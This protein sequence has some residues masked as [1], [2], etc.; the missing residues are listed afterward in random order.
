MKRKLQEILQEKFDYEETCL[1]L[2]DMNLRFSAVE[3]EVFEGT[4]L[5][6]SS[7]AQEVRGMI[8]CENP[9]VT[10]ETTEFH[11]TKIQVR[12]QY[13]A[14][15]MAE[16]MSDQGTFVI[17]SNV[18]EYLLPFRADITRHYLTS[19]IGK[20]KTLNDFTN[21]CKLNWEEALRVFKSPYFVNVLQH[22]NGYLKLLYR[23]LTQHGRGT[24]EMEEFLVGCGK[25]KRNGFCI[26]RPE[27]TY[28]A[29]TKIQT[30]FLDIEKQE[31]GDIHIEAFSDA[32]FIRL[33]KHQIGM[34]DF[35]GKHAEL[36]YQIVPGG[37]HAG[38]N[39]GRILL[40]T[41]F[42]TEAVQIEVTMPPQHPEKS[43]AWKSTKLRARMEQKYLEFCREELTAAQWKEEMEPLLT[44]AERIHPDNEW[45]LLYQIYAL[46][47]CGEKAEADRL[48]HNMARTIT[49]QRT[50]LSAFYLYL[51]TI[52]E[53]PSY[54]R[55]VTKRIREIY[56]KYPNHPVLV[57]ILLRT[58]EAL[59][60]NPERKYQWLRKYM[61]SGSCS[62]VFYEETAKLLCNHPELLRQFDLFERR[63]L[64]WM[65]KQGRLTSGLVQRIFAMAQSQKQFEPL[66]FQLLCRG[67][68]MNPEE[69]ALR[70]ICGYL[71]K[72]NQYGDV[73]FPWF[74]KG[75][76]QHLKIAG[77][78]EAY[79]LSWNKANGMLPN[80]VLHYFSRNSS[81]PAKRKAMLYAHMVKN[82]KRL[83]KSWDA[84]LVL[85]RNFAK[86]ELLAGEMNEDLA[87]IYE[88]VRRQCTKAEWDSWK[89]QAE[90]CYRI[91]VMNDAMPNLHI[92]QAE[93]EE[94]QQVPVF[95][96]GTYIYLEKKPFVVLYESTGGRLYTA[97]DQFHLKKML[98]GTHIYQEEEGAA[99][100]Q[101]SDP[102]ADSRSLKEQLDQF[103]GPLAVMEERIRAAEA[104][105]M[106][107]QPYEEKLMLHMLFTGTFLPEHE[108][109][110]Q[111]LTECETEEVLLRAYETWFSWQ[112][113]RGKEPFP[114]AVR[115]H[116]R[117][118]LDKEPVRQK[119]CRAA[120]LKNCACDS[121]KPEQED[122]Q[123]A[124]RI[125]KGFVLEQK[126]FDFYAKLPEKL[127]RKYLL[128]GSDAVTCVDT[129]GEYLRICRTAPGWQDKTGD[130]KEVLP[131]I[132]SY[133][134]REIRSCPEHYVIRNREGDCIAEGTLPASETENWGDTRYGKLLRLSAAGNTQDAYQY[135]E[136]TDLTDVLFQA[137]EE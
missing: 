81:L 119:F 28:K 116:L 67:Y 29:G 71:I 123:I 10:C 52:G 125:L 77:L 64:V 26:A 137:I 21:L 92:L 7:S 129:P 15:A 34:Y 134:C 63:V 127:Q 110:Y 95:D 45:T 4:F 6:H 42:Q 73:Y 100:E 47:M 36:A 99:Q 102:A 3:N 136:L 68:R 130:M 43:D 101:K 31:W 61:L 19:S 124:E 108:A 74:Q 133:T 14:D 49:S 84:Y 69:R 8:T 128:F 126:A 96:R 24:H 115:A 94:I 104:Q 132:Y 93:K 118:V 79:I 5:F 27:R 40:K 50:P 114:Q 1:L 23:G 112:Y 2:P 25:K 30:D 82:R 105:G 91:R 51:T 109:V 54:I 131:G 57:W 62:P 66:F 60:R 55:D 13:R 17:T 87:V 113:M 98:S 59:V 44:E 32:A 83:G 107:V 22:D 88:E 78:Y 135:A 86:Q 65:M 111:K 80:E 103:A 120:F 121:E 56:L 35:I 117:Q 11:G 41:A 20:I 97:R 9:H 37:L 16:G 76:V 58:D 33:E 72:C 106:D 85:I 12:F 39:Y 18:G 48:S 89:K 38:K 90:C 70:T 75:I 122:W 46:L 53:T